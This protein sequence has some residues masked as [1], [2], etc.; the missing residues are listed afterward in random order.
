MIFFVFSLIVFLAEVIIAVT[1]LLNLMKWDKVFNESDK[2]FEEIKPKVK[3]IAGLCRKLSEQ[4][5]ELAPIWVD[6]TKEKLIKLALCQS[7]NILAGI[8]ACIIS[9][10]VEKFVVERINN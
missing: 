9:K 2:F 3:E 1:I 8:L 10:Q 6:N 4:L 7:K 5:V